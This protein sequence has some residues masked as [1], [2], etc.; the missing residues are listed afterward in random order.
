[1]YALLVAF[2]LRPQGVLEPLRTS[3]CTAVVV[4]G[5]HGS[6][7]CEAPSSVLVL[8]E[9][10]ELVFQLAKQLQLYAR[11]PSCHLPRA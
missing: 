2:V 11:A 4:S 9:L 1:M 3:D 5:V 8:T 6:T 10:R 7:E